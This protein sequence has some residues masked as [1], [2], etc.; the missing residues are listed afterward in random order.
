MAEYHGLPQNEANAAFLKDPY[1][2]ALEI[3]YGH[4][5]TGHKSQGGQWQTPSSALSGLRTG[6]GL[7]GPTRYLPA[8][9]SGYFCWIVLC[10]NLNPEMLRPDSLL[11]A[12]RR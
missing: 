7:D 11:F 6:R 3:K 1:I 5:I 12:H 9:K 2:N 10:A 4:A 8:Q